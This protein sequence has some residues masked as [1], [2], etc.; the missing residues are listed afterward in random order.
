MDLKTTKKQYI[1]ID[2]NLDTNPKGRQTEVTGI[3]WKWTE[4]ILVVLAGAGPPGRRRQARPK[5]HMRPFWTQIR[6]T[7]EL[8]TRM[9]QN[10][11]TL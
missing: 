11:R 3:G 7:I 4:V 1:N 8:S 10:Y 2:L 6:G 9:E 5:A